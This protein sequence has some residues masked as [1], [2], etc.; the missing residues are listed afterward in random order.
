MSYIRTDH[1]YK[2]FTVREK[3][4]KGHIFREKRTVDAL[5]DLSFQVEKGELIGCIGPNGAGKSTLLDLLLRWKTPTSGTIRLD[6]R[7]LD[8]Y[9]RTDLGRAVSLVP[10]GETS[11]FAFTLREYV[12]FGR[13]PRVAALAMPSARDEAA[14]ESALRGTGL[15]PLADREVPTLS[16]GERQLLL[17]AR[18]IAQETPVML[19]D[20]P[21]SALDPANSARVARILRDLHD[22]GTTLLWTT[23]DSSF[24]A[25]HATHAVL[26]RAG[27][28]LA[29]GPA[30]TTLTA[31]ALTALYSTPLR[32]F[33]HDGRLLVYAP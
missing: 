25:A 12:L 9:T 2:T 23:H 22:R 27:R 30:S 26:L 20:E 24:A 28:I 32:T 16:G 11:R 14:A 3:R 13:A 10:Q 21:T 29:A 17:L 18:A 33:R 6:G 5:R 19:L 4:R 8:A 31:D 7:P 1:L 15:L